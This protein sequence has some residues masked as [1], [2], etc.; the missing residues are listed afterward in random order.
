MEKEVIIGHPQ[1]SL[2]FYDHTNKCMVDTI[3]PELASGLWEE[4]NIDNALI[5]EELGI[6]AINYWHPVFN[7][8]TPVLPGFQWNADNNCL[9]YEFD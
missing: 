7:K 8:Y 9:D 5:N 6:E 4:Y 1:P 3:W 2:K